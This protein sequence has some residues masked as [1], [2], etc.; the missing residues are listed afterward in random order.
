MRIPSQKNLK[1]NPGQISGSYRRLGISKYEYFGCFCPV[2]FYPPLFRG[3]IKIDPNYF[4][5]AT[6][7]IMMQ[8]S[9]TVLFSMPTKTATN[10]T[11]ELPIH[12]VWAKA[13][14]S[15]KTIQP[16]KKEHQR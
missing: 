3:V 6:A 7:L 10:F 5:C 15:P 12:M 1:K 4:S 11:D 16:P 8:H 14:L 2:C 13:F 9:V